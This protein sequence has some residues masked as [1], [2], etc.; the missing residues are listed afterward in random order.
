MSSSFLSRSLSALRCMPAALRNALSIPAETRLATPLLAIAG[1]TL[2]LTGAY[3]YAAGWLTPHRLTP[4]RIISTFNANAGTYAGFRRNQAKG[5]CVTG[6]FDGNGNASQ[7]SSASVFDA[8]RTPVIGRFAIPGGN[9]LISDAGSPVRSLALLFQLADGEQWRTGMNN[10]P[11]FAVH[12]PQA[13]YEQLTASR[14]DPATGKP[15]PA[16]MKAFFNAHPETAAFR[17]WVAAHPPSSGLENGTYYSINAFQ[18]INAAGDKQ[19]VRWAMVPEQSYTPVGRD[20][21]DPDFLSRGLQQQLQ[22]AGQGGLHWHL[23]LTLAKPGDV[24][25]DATQAW[26]AD[27]PSIDA[28]ILTLTQAITQ[29]DGPCRDVNFDPLILPRG[30][31]PSA[32]P[33]LAARSGAYSRSFNLRTREEAAGLANADADAHTR[34]GGA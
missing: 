8:A 31:Q 10:T 28:G 21:K 1:V 4:S 11:V 25:D 24:T 6:Y 14:P 5:I 32:D 2:A 15:D 33:L 7:F 23:M 26:P 27:R 12:T 19:Y 29:D 20:I 22:K 34:S 16:R 9:P 3:A 13:F 17:Q 18:L 30:I